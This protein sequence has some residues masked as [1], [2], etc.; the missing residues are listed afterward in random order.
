MFHEKYYSVSWFSKCFLMSMPDDA[1]CFSTFSNHV[2]YKSFSLM[3]LFHISLM[4]LNNML[5]GCFKIH[6][7]SSLYLNRRLTTAGYGLGR[8]FPLMVYSFPPAENSS[9]IL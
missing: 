2:S 9:R 5:V 3:S 8:L 7:M 4:S 6:S 1:N